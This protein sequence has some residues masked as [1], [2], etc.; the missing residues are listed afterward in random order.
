MNWLNPTGSCSHFARVEQCI[1]FINLSNNEPCRAQRREQP[2]DPLLLP[3][4]TFLRASRTAGCAIFS[5]TPNE[6]SDQMHEL[7]VSRGFVRRA[8]AEDLAEVKAKEAIADEAAAAKKKERA[9]AAAK[10]RLE[11]ANGRPDEGNAKV[12]AEAQ[13][14]CLAPT[15]YMCTWIT[16]KRDRR[17][18]HRAFACVDLVRSADRPVQRKFAPL[19]TRSASSTPRSGRPEKARPAGA[20]S[21]RRGSCLHLFYVSIERELHVF[22][23][24]TSRAHAIFPRGMFCFSVRASYAMVLPP[25]TLAE[26]LLLVLSTDSIACAGRSSP[27]SSLPPEETLEPATVAEQVL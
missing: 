19:W 27:C 13:Y 2:C 22:G 16:P 8:D 15:A 7:L 23:R 6:P 14:V 20:E 3:G 18:R 9:E 24:R 11:R 26:S 17:L 21:C 5:L 1:V 25:A 10:R 4:V 12:G